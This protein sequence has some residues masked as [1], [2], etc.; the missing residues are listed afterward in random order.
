MKMVVGGY[1]GAGTIT[2]GGYDYHTGDRATGE[3]RDFLAGQCIG[4][5]LNYA[6]R[7]KTPLMIYVF[8][9]GAVSSNGR[10][11]DSVG[12]GGKGEWTSDNS[13]TAASFML[14]FDPETQPTVKTNQIGFFSSAGSVVTTSSPAANNPNLLV[15]TV[16]LNY[17]AFNKQEGRFDAIFDTL[18]IS[19]GLGA[20][21]NLIAFDGATSL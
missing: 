19:H 12:G 4:A 8:S 20:Y 21:S 15:N 14:A 17:L 2:M 9:D 5:C 13:G 3:Q 16:L 7:K 6:Q 10:I 11:D 1:A 18:G